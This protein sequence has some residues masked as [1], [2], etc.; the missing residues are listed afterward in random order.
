MKEKPVYSTDNKQSLAGKKTSSKSGFQQ[1]EGPIKVRLEKKGRAGKTVTVLFNLPMS[2]AE[3]RQLMKS[4]Q[5]LL[6]CGGSLKDSTI[7]LRGELADRVI[8]VLKDRGMTA[9][10]AGG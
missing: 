4:L 6:A 9:I 10:R 2:E 5:T 3:A 8:Q 7:E 1:G